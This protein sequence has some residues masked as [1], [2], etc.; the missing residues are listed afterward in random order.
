MEIRSKLIR[1]VEGAADTQ[2]AA[3]EHVGVDH[4]STDVVVAEE[5]LNGPN[6]VA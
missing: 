6:V 2:P 3:F 4:G 1:L 5:L